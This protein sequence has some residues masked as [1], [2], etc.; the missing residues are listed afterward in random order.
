MTDNISDANHQ[1]NLTA[2]E[3][4][5][6]KCELD[7]VWVHS[8]PNYLGYLYPDMT[9]AEYQKQFDS[10]PLESPRLVAARQAAQA[11]AAATTT[12]AAATIHKLPTA[13]N[14]PVSSQQVFAEVFELGEAMAAKNK[15]GD[16]IFIE[17][18]GEADPE[19]A[20]YVPDVDPNYIYNIDLLKAVMM[21]VQLDMPLYAHGMH[22]TGKTTLLEQYAART[23]RPLMRVQHTISTEEAHV[24]GQ[25]VVKGGD[26]VFEPGPLAVCMRYGLI[27]LADEYDFALPAVTSV[28]QPVLEGKK[29]VIK[30]APPEWRVVKPHKNFR[31][32]ATGNTNG[33][34]DETGLYQGTQIQNA[35]NFSRFGITI[36]VGYMEPPQET[37]VVAGQGKI[38]Q[39]DAR[40][41][42]DLAGHIRMSFR[43][44]DIGVPVSPRELIKA[45]TLGRTL[46]GEWKQGIAL[47]YSN[48]LS[49]T[50]RKAVMDVVNRIF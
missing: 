43:L 16:P 44:G 49:S 20:D 26:T 41:L 42:V 31:F 45:A 24:L 28:Y 39:E 37:A 29:L 38:T 36:E 15:R 3:A 23:R 25:Y 47:A 40:K 50:D 10:A 32:L 48:R 12:M 34:G 19:F 21:A 7:G 1:K 35:A 13:A 14:A 8:I 2:T 30:E 18:L 6:V 4:N 27:Y 11:K 9:V 46:G 22:G 5:G 33:G 17:V